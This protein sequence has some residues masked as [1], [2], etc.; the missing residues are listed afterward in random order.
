M[1][2]VTAWV[3]LVDATIVNGCMELLKGGHRS[4]KVAQHTGCAGGTWYI[5][6][7]PSAMASELSVDVTRDSVVC[8][9][10]KGSV[11]LLNN[12]I[13]HR[14][15]PNN[16]SDIRW[17][18]DLRWQRPSEANGFEGVKV[19]YQP[20]LVTPRPLTNGGRRGCC[21]GV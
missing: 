3:P 9:V 8:E 20:V 15:L 10:R 21:T 4:G 19:G 18:L 5:E 17:S 12:L 7:S 14:S 2:Q 13:P 11:L 1:L 6:T 16:S